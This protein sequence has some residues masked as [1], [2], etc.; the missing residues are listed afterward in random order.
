MDMMKPLGG[1]P[2]NGVGGVGDHASAM[3]LFGVVMLALYDRESTGL[4][5]AVS[6]SLIAN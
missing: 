2:V 4:G 1:A 6:T 5:A 3:S